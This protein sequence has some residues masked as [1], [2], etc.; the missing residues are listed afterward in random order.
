MKLG[1]LLLYVPDVQKSVTF[2]EKAFGLKCRFISIEDE[3]G[4][5]EMDTGAAA[6]GFASHA[7]AQSN[8]VKYQPCRPDSPPPAMEVG[9][10]TDDVAGAYQKAVAAGAVSVAEPKQKPWGQSV[11]YVRDN[12]GFLVEICSPME[13]K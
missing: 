9:L 1:Y 3:N 8:G 5:A 2:Y 6:L 10:V 12:N 13:L 11:A 7:L 4:Y